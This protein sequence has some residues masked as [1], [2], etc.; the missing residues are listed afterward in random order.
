MKGQR[1]HNKNDD[2]RIMRKDK[3]MEERMEVKDEE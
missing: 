3:S 1:L 2:I